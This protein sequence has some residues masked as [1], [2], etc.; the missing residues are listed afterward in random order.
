[1]SQAF[2]VAVLG[3]T[4]LVGQTMIELLEERDFPVNR[5]YPLASKRSAGSTVSFKGEDIEV[6]DADDFDWS[7]VQFGFFSAGGSISAKFAPLAAE[8]GCIVIDNTSEFR[9]EPDIPLVVP[10]VNAHALAEFRNRNII[11]N[12]NCSTI[13]M[14]VALKPI[15]DAVGIDRIN[16]CTYQSV[17]GAGKE[18]MEELAKQTAG[19]L[20]ARE[21]KNE[22]FS[23]QIAF[24]VIPQIDV[25]QDNDYTKEE[26]KMVWETQ[27]IMGDQ[28]ILVN[29]TAVRVPVFYGHAEAIHLETSS[30]I[31]AQH[32]KELLAD[33]PGVT[34]Y[35]GNEQFP[36]Q[37]SSASGNDI[38]HVGR[39]RN[40]ISHSCGLNLW[41]V[42]DNIRKGAATNSIQIAETLIRD[43]L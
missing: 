42:S 9:Y 14:M 28:S 1:M 32:V 24:N 22:A 38:V 7:L 11:A 5:L 31:D 4:G 2:D 27:K 33:A 12:P 29:A 21:V 13:Q 40:D 15:Q 20:N 34:V 39:I 10:E 41:V 23:R 36:T 25:F 43:Y 26:M 16:V 18:A 3:A 30:A 8:E 17:S 19:L 37:V 6:L 35:D